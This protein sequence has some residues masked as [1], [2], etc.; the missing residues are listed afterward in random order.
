M[1][2]PVI[3]AG[4]S[5]QF[6]CHLSTNSLGRFKVILLF[7]GVDRVEPAR[8]SKDVNQYFLCMDLEQLASSWY[9]ILII[10]LNPRFII[11]GRE[12]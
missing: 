8:F 4:M 9:L 12:A 10:E 11:F 1:N 7:L 2:G 5:L 6:Q 3:I